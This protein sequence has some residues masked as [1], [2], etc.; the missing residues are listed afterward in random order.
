M[1]QSNAYTNQM[2]DGLS[3]LF[4]KEQGRGLGILLE[5]LIKMGWIFKTERVGDLG[6]IPVG[7]QKQR[8]GFFHNALVDD[9]ARRFASR[10]FQDIVQMVDMNVQLVGIGRWREHTQRVFRG[11]DGKLLVEQPEEA[12]YEPVM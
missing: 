4:A 5:I 11:V 10:A 12:G 1:N 3:K 8:L 7:I 9:L 6:G 2:L